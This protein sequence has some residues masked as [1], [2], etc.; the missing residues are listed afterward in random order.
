MTTPTPVTV[1]SQD[2]VRLQTRLE[3]YEDIV[4]KS[5]GT[6]SEHALSMIKYYAGEVSNV[7]AALLCMGNKEDYLLDTSGVDFDQVARAMGRESLTNTSAGSDDLE[8]EA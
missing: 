8:D 2:L 1:L 6:P 5:R 7:R 4:I 3:M